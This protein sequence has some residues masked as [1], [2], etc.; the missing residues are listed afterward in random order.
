MMY[1]LINH[2]VNRMWADYDKSKDGYLTLEDS[3]EFIQ[4]SFG[5]SHTLSD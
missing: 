1:K 2:S 3:R 4:D 5:H